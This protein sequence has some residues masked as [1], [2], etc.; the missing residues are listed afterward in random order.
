MY[1]GYLLFVRP[2]WLAFALSNTSTRWSFCGLGL[3][4]AGGFRTGDPIFIVADGSGD[5]E[6]ILHTRALYCD[7]MTLGAAWSRFQQRLGTTDEQSLLTEVTD[8]FPKFDADSPLDVLAMVEQKRVSPPMQ[9][10]SIAIV[11][12]TASKI[13]ELA[14]EQVLAILKALPAGAQT[15]WTQRVVA[16]NNDLPMRK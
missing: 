3:Q 5:L 16:R 13:Q 2:S 8:V 4:S 15:S 11:R 12:D 10:C 7:P 6:I 9:L 14:P 1:V